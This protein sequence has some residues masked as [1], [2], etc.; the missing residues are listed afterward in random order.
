MADLSIARV[1]ASYR[2]ASQDGVWV[3]RLVKSTEAAAPDARGYLPLLTMHHLI[4]IVHE[5]RRLLRAPEP[6]GTPA[7]AARLSQEL[8]DDGTAR[9]RSKL[10]NDKKKTA[11]Q[12]FSDVDTANQDAYDLFL[13]PR[14]RFLLPFAKDLGIVRVDGFVASSTTGISYRSTVAP[15]TAGSDMLARSSRWGNDIRVLLEAAPGLTPQTEGLFNFSGLS[16]TSTDYKSKDFLVDRYGALTASQ[17]L[18]LLLIEGDMNTSLHYFP[19]AEVG[20]QESVFR[21]RLADLVHDLSSLSKMVDAAQPGEFDPVLPVLR[22]DAAQRVI[23]PKGRLVRN[24]AVHY[25][26]TDPNIHL[27]PDRSMLGLVEAVYPGMTWEQ[28]NADMLEVTQKL[29]TALA[30]W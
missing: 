5:V 24:L 30:Q 20:S 29:S 6:F 23:D 25:A 12:V 2:M 22:S 19:L 17:K 18:T 16:V 9:T 7:H 27:R 4:R 15:D 10:L 8:V 1:R 28:L 13:Q 26:L 3:S 14:F 11:A 21:M